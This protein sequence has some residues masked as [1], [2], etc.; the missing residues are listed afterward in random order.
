VTE[1]FWFTDFSDEE[2]A[3]KGSPFQPFL[4]ISGGCF[5]LP[6]WF[7]TEAECNAFIATIPAGTPLEAT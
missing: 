4:Q 3:V 2:D 7:K 1:V 5:P 6:M